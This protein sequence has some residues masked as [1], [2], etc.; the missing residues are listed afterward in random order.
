MN[1]EQ[2]LY[3]RQARRKREDLF[4]LSE[5]MVRFV[6]PHLRIFALPFI[7]LK[8]IVCFADELAAILRQLNPSGGWT[9]LLKFSSYQMFSGERVVLIKGAHLLWTPG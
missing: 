5:S 6:L 1:Q 8:Q 9:F 2:H 3:I 7:Q 4:G